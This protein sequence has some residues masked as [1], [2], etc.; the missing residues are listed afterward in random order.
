MDKYQQIINLW[1]NPEIKTVTDLENKLHN[2]RVLFAYNSNKIENPE[3]D[4]HDTR[5]LFDNGK[6]INYTG[7]ARTLLEQQNQK[8]CYDILKE[9][10]IAK[11][12]MTVNLVKEVHLLLTAGTYDERR[13]VDNNERSGEFK[14]VDYVTGRYEVGSKPENVE[15]DI[16][17]LLNEINCADDENILKI[18]AYFHARF[19][20][21]HPFADGNGRVGRTL[22]N[23][24]LMLNNHP[25]LIVYDEDKKHYYEALEKYDSDEEIQPL[26]E[27]IKS[28][29][30]KTWDSTLKR[31]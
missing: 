27:F 5:E 2:F 6:V 31:S 12:P 1:R 11:K 19:E 16:V 17:D 20:Y 9:Y 13:Y 4:Y 15:K 8:I 26:Y 18:G 30:I 29:T 25:P 3:T 21:I 7:N 14:K 22:L 28:Q 23:Y 24:Y 10:I